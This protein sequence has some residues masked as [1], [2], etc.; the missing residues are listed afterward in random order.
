MTLHLRIHRDRNYPGPRR[1]RGY[2]Q[3]G[4]T[5]VRRGFYFGPLIV[6]VWRDDV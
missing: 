5:F 6:T 2:R 4:R 3:V 1:W